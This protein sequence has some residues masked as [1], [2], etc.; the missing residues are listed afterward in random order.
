MGLVNHV[1][2]RRV[3]VLHAT[4]CVTDRWQCAADTNARKATVRE[5]YA[6]RRCAI[7]ASSTKCWAECFNSE[8]YQEGVLRVREKRRGL[9]G[10]VT[11]RLWA[12]A[13]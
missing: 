7:S 12:C 10:Q 11:G 1:V 2:P 13:R 3:G 6:P 4:V 9:Q 5:C 8:D